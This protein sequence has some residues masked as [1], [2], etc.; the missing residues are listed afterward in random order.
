MTLL[1]LAPVRTPRDP[2]ARI[3]PADLLDM[4]GAGLYE[5]VEGHLV[6]KP[7]G[8]LANLVAGNV[9]LHLKLHC[10][11]NHAGDVLP[12]QS[13]ECF[14]H[15]EDLVRRPDVA[16]IAAARVPASLPRGH[17]RFAP[18][19]AVEVISPTN[20]VLEMDEKLADYWSAGVP[21]VWIVNPDARLVRVHRPR[22]PILEYSGDDVLI[23]DPVLPG[24]AVPVREFWP[25]V[26][27]AA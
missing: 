20:T 22:Q 10:R 16:F 26:V 2:N 11:T 15:D 4:E 25:A 18:D 14:P 21:M 23:G 19:L 8:Y 6:E 7:M 27:P 5:L 3:T 24:F 9:T 17:V 12:E 1:T 13:F